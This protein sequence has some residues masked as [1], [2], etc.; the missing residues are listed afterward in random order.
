MYIDV[1][2]L[3]Q[4]AQNGDHNR[5]L[6]KSYSELHHYSERRQDAYLDRNQHKDKHEPLLRT[7][8]E[9]PPK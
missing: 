3:F 9:E 6:T 7:Q 5:K 8:S 2:R 4:N 1:M